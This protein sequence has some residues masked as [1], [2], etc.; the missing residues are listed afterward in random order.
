MEEQLITNSS[1]KYRESLLQITSPTLLSFESSH[2]DEDDIRNI[3]DGVVEP[4]Q[5]MIYRSECDFF[6]FLA[7]Y[8]ASGMLSEL[9]KSSSEFGSSEYMLLAV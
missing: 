6:K 3:V 9:T 4:Y 2:M 8:L 1:M 5:I 7:R